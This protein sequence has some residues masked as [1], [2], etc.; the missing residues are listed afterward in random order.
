[1]DRYEVIR[2]VAATFEREVPEYRDGRVTIVQIASEPGKHTKVAVATDVPDL[3]PVQ[4]C[5]GPEGVRIRAIVEHLGRERVDI[6]PFDE[7]PVRFVCSALAPADIKRVLLDE[8]NRAM[9][10]IVDDGELERCLGEHGI[11][12]RLAADLTG[13]RLD[14]ISQSRL[15]EARD[16]LRDQLSA[17]DDDLID[18]LF[19]RGYTHIDQ[20]AGE[21]PEGLAAF[22]EL[23][24]EV[25]RSIIDIA[26]SAR[27]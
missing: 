6:V 16:R 11:N 23:S 20:L 19:R 10:L 3:D 12:L 25:A 13:W 7:A 22:A 9:E 14:V 8:E 27:F 21:S 17:V 26:R 18:H 4:A 5:V 15:D 24:L 1:M 2:R